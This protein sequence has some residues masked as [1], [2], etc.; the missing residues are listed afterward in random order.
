MVRLNFYWSISLI[1]SVR[2]TI[3][4]LPGRLISDGAYFS[5]ISVAA[6]AVTSRG[7]VTMLTRS[8]HHQAHKKLG[9]LHHRWVEANRLLAP[10]IE[11]L[12]QLLIV[13]VLLFIVGLLD[14]LLSSSIPVS[15]FDVLLLVAGVI[16]C[17]FIIAVGVYTIWTV[18][19]GC[20]HPEVSP[21]QSTIS[22][23]L[24]THGP[25]WIASV[26]N[27]PAACKAVWLKL[28]H[29][30][31]RVNLD[32]S[33]L[34]IF[35]RQRSST[36]DVAPDQEATQMG[37]A[38]VRAQRYK[39]ADAD[40][41]G[42]ND[43]LTMNE[44]RAFHAVLYQTHEDDILD[45]AAAALLP[46]SRSRRP[47]AWQLRPDQYK[48]PRPTS[49]EKESTLYLLSTEASI[50]SNLTAAAAICLFEPEALNQSSE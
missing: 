8:R 43:V 46:L 50:R 3:R 23:A 35:R 18:V 21:Y 25:D 16:S 5:Q 9:E 37:P 17:V 27:S 34:P 31:G 30:L 28:M 1:L 6:L 48:R 14:M 15:G 11:A 10:A 42:P 4:I 29:R 49:F 36:A 39:A 40:Y 7:Y 12:P 19:H 44:H 20:M 41:H 32:V 13:P 38:P 26:K 45:Q 33:I 47:K 24:V 22:R 2:T